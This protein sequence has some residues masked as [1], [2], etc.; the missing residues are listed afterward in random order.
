MTVSSIILYHLTASHSPE[1]YN[2]LSIIFS[3][4]RLMKS[5]YRLSLCLSVRPCAPFQLLTLLTSFFPS[6]FL[7]KLWHR[8][9]LQ[10]NICVA[11]QAM[12]QR[13]KNIS[14]PPTK[15]TI[16]LSYVATSTSTFH[17]PANARVVWCLCWELLILLNE[18]QHWHW[19]VRNF[20]GRKQMTT[21]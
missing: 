20:I 19:S 8:R 18:S 14:S 10:T 2:H 6:K 13:D 16:A 21:K 9:S 5:A 17:A 11:P 15:C 7:W 1:Q 4:N 12:Q 3:P